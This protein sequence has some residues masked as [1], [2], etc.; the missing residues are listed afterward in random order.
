MTF[1]VSKTV[2]TP[3]S[4]WAP[5]QPCVAAKEF[6]TAFRTHLEVRRLLLVIKIVQVV[7]RQQPV[8][9]KLRMIERD[10]VDRSAI[11]F[12]TT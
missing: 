1:C 11:Y 8:A 3:G 5:L 10:G 2:K 4:V 9:Q 6:V 7:S 12:C